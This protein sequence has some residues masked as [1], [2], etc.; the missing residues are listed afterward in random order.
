MGET[1]RIPAVLAVAATAGGVLERIAVLCRGAREAGVP[2]L[3]CTA[4]S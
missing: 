3:H 1:S 2:V 4:E